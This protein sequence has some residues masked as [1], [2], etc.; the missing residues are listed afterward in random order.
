VTDAKIALYNANI[1]DRFTFIA[2]VQMTTN[3]GGLP[4]IAV[5]LVED[6][7]KPRDAYISFQDA[8]DAVIGDVNRGIPSRIEIRDIRESKL[9]HIQYDVAD[10]AGNLLKLKC[11][12]FAFSIGGRP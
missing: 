4:V 5:T 6:A 7:E 11:W 10:T 9:A 8:T 2:G 1:R 3:P 12:D